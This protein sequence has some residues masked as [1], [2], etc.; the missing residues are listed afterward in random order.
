MLQGPLRD[1]GQGRP[2]RQRAQEKKEIML[3]Y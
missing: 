3:S 2:V 1:G